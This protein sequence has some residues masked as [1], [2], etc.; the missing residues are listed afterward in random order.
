MSKTNRKISFFVFMLS[1][2]LL[3]SCKIK[4]VAPEQVPVSYTGSGKDWDVSIEIKDKTELQMKFTY[5]KDI[6]D[7]R[8]SERL[9]FS[10]VTEREGFGHLLLDCSVDS[11]YPSNDLY[12]IDFQDIN[13]KTFEVGFLT[14]NELA[15]KNAIKEDRFFIDIFW[16]KNRI[17]YSDHIKVL[18]SS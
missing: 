14:E 7:L 3:T 15:L 5:K 12:F 2:L 17:N 18:S 4:E 9:Q 1:L 6:E 10:V 11:N 16:G 8:K 13:S